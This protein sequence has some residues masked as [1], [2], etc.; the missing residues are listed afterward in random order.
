M[1]K[2][3]KPKSNELFYI[4]SNGKKSD[5]LI[6]EPIL[7]DGDHDEALE[8]GLIAA[9][10]AGVPDDAILHVYGRLPRT[11]RSKP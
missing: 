10:N 7:A 4:D 5:A 11:P 9:R 3:R 1:T 6:H 8:S 2:T